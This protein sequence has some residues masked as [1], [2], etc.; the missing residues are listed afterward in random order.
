MNDFNPF[1]G[2]ILM[3]A[4]REHGEQAAARAARNASAQPLAAKAVRSSKLSALV[5][6]ARRIANTPVS[7]P[8][9]LPRRRMAA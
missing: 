1:Y 3:T 2:V 4:L 7:L 6:T 8:R 9:S 5:A